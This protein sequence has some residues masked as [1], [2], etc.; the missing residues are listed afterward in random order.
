MRDV[1]AFMPPGKPGRH[2]EC[3]GEPA[4]AGHRGMA[5]FPGDDPQREEARGPNIRVPM[6]TMV[7]P[8]SMAMR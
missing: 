5:V 3:T 4:A 8:S 7:A 1:Q 6:R 2:R